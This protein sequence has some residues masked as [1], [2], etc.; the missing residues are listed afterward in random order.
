M[1]YQSNTY[2]ASPAVKHL[3]CVGARILISEKVHFL[4]NTSLPLSIQKAGYR[5]ACC[6]VISVHGGTGIALD[7][8]LL[9]RLLSSRSEK[10][11]YAYNKIECS[12]QDRPT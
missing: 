7:V 11:E 5:P 10:Y 3:W 8:R 2:G 6:H 9:T 4:T 12:C 1:H